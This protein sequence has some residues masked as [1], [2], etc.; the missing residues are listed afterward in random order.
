MG[1]RWKCEG[2]CG[3]WKSEEDLIRNTTFPR[4]GTREDINTNWFC[5]NCATRIGG[6]VA[7]SG[8]NCQICQ[9]EV[10][11]LDLKLSFC[12]E[13]V[14]CGN[15]FLVNSREAIAF[16]LNSEKEHDFKLNCLNKMKKQTNDGY[17][18]SNCLEEVNRAIEN[19]IREKNQRENSGSQQQI[20]TEALKARFKELENKLFKTKIVEKKDLEKSIQTETITTANKETQTDLTSKQIAELM[21][22]KAQIQVLVSKK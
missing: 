7:P 11:A 22:F 6:G 17:L 21:E 10:N 14:F 20:S 19:L 2:H 16:V 8:H 1:F 4:Y 15:C 18:P 9:R 12:S 5:R 13:L 3:Q